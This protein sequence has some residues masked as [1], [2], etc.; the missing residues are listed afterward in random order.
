[1]PDSLSCHIHKS[2]E[3]DDAVASDPMLHQDAAH[4]KMHRGD[5][6]NQSSGHLF[7]PTV[8]PRCGEPLVPGIIQLHCCWQQIMCTLSSL[9]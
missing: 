8:E 9:G 5:G 2:T 4:G 7:S 3:P 6:A 1:M